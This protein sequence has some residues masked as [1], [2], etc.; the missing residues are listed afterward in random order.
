MALCLVHQSQAMNLPLVYQGR[1]GDDKMEEMKKKKTQKRRK[2]NDILT[3]TS[4]KWQHLVKTLL[5]SKTVVSKLYST[6]TMI[7]NNKSLLVNIR[8]EWLVLVLVLMGAAQNGEGLWFSHFVGAG[9][10]DL[11]L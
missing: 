7:Q 3:F 11:W 9:R 10:S 8:R 1:S 2:T 6:L 4:G 5:D